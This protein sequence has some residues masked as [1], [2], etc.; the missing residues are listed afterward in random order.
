MGKLENLLKLSL[1]FE[2][3]GKKVKLY[4]VRIIYMDR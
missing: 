3:G 1:L 2:L 4:K